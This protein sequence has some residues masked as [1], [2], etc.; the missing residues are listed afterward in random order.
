MDLFRTKSKEISD[1]L[2]EVLVFEVLVFEV[3]DLRSLAFEV[4]GFDTPVDTACSR[5]VAG[6]IWFNNYLNEL[7]ES[8]MGKVTIIQSHVPFRFGDGR[9]VHCFISARTRIMIAN[10]SCQV[11]LK[12]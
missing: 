10:T 2:F 9:K 5:T 7:N 6:E 11:K 8:L 1:V 3:L 12:L 4:L